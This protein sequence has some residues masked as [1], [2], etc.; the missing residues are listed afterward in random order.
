ML[1]I[2]SA[3]LLLAVTPALAEEGDPCVGHQ[4]LSTPRPE[5]GCLTMRLEV[6]ASPDRAVRA[7]VYP[8][9]MDLN[10][11]PDIESRV[12]MRGNDAKLLTSRDF[13]SPRGTNGYYVVKAKWSPDSQFFVFTM[14]SSGGHSPWQFPTWVYSREKNAFISFNAMIA[15]DPILSDDFQFTGPHTIKAMTWEAAGSDKQVPV[16]VD[17][18]DAVAKPLPPARK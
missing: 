2:M 13:A 6:H 12:V 8:A 5:G 4:F 14:S 1:R 3:I 17:L 7:I 18:A 11:S 16:V 9:G 15:G 10:A